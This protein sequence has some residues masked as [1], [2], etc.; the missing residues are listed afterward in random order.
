VPGIIED[1]RDL[2]DAPS[3]HKKDNGN[4]IA[5]LGNSIG[6]NVYTRPLIE[7]VEDP[8]F[9]LTSATEA[10]LHEKEWHRRAQELK[11]QGYTAK[12]IANMLGKTD[13]HVANVLRQPWAQE[14]MNN[15]MKEDASSQI[16]EFLENECLPSLKVLVEI[17]DNRE[18]RAADRKSAADSLADRFLGRAAQPIYDVS[19]D[20]PVDQLTN[21]E[22]SAQVN[23][24]VE[25]MAA[26]PNDPNKP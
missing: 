7:N 13:R 24:L 8:L 26:T 12:D 14:R 5:N 9:G 2:G 6:N 3:P 1:W 25:G 21:D 15:R 11:L 16:R 18:Y 19:K 17:R 23:R 22:L 20:K 10:I 4:P